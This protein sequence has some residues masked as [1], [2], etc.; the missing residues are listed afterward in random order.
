[1]PPPTVDILEWMR[2][3]ATIITPFAVMGLGF[4]ISARAASRKTLMETIER[5]IEALSTKLDRGR[6]ECREDIQAMV[7]Q[8][9]AFQQ[10]VAKNYPVR[11]ELEDGLSGIREDIRFHFGRGSDDPHR[12]R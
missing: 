12:R 6:E 10:E 9:S 4:W 8:V 11:R 1:M 3:G 5:K 2:F 7:A